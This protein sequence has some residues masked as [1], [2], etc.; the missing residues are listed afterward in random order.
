MDYE[1]FA[2]TG[3]LPAVVRID[4]LVSFC[5]TIRLVSSKRVEQPINHLTSIFFEL[6]IG[7]FI[8]ESFNLISI[9]AFDKVLDNKWNKQLVDVLNALKGCN[10][11]K[12]CLRDFQQLCNGVWVPN[13]P[14]QI[15]V[16]VF[17]NQRSL[18]P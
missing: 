18:N 11:L 17:L 4:W 13:T 8:W 14:L 1:H 10:I 16:K 3:T 12:V 9:L 15:G 2:E 5:Q 7:L 6:K